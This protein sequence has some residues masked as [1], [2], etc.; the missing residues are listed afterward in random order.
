MSSNSGHP[1]QAT[2]GPQPRLDVVLD[3]ASEF[4][5]MEILPHLDGARALRMRI[6]IRQLAL[7]RRAFEQ[8]FEAQTARY[9]QLQEL[10]GIS[11]SWSEL[12]MTLARRIRERSFSGN[13][14][15]LR[16]YLEKSVNDSLRVDNPKWLT[17]D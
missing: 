1:E 3:A 4:L 14:L 13:P 8:T 16:D 9:A 12:Q 15:V 10:L 7:A 17:D 5:E 6:T 2:V 11:G